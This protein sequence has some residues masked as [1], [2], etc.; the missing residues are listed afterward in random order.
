MFKKTP[1]PYLGPVP[2]VTHLH[3][4]RVFDDSDGY[5]EA[6]YLPPALNILKQKFLNPVGVPWLPGTSVYE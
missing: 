5:P 3:G 4:A 2:T 1:G 6:W